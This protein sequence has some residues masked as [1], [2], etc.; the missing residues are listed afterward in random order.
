[1]DCSGLTL[2]NSLGSSD[3]FNPTKM[4]NLGCCCLLYNGGDRVVFEESGIDRWFEL[5]GSN[6]A[7]LWDNEQDN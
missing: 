1:M 3:E 5:Y 6:S 4:G 2:N 7:I